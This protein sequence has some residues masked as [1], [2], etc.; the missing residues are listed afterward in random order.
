MD[1]ADAIKWLNDHNVYKDEEQKIPFEL[2]DVRTVIA[3]TVF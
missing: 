3:L 2:G 1:Y